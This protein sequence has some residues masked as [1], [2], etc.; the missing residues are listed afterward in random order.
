MVIQVIQST[1]NTG[2]ACG[3]ITEAMKVI[4]IEKKGKHLNTLEEYHL[5]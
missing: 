4:K 5:K 3:S 2:H 1:S